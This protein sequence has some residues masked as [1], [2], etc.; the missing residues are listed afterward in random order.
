MISTARCP[1]SWNARSRWSGIP[2]PTWMSGDVTSMPSFTRNGRPSLS[3]ASSPP[4][5]R[6]STALRVRSASM[7]AAT[8]AGA[9]T[10]LRRKSRAPKRRRI[11]KLRL[12]ALLFVLGLLGLSSF[13]FGLLTSVSA[14]VSG[15]DPQHQ[16]FQQ[17]NTYVYANN[18]TSI[19][20]VLH[21]SEARVIVPSKDISPWVKHAI[22]AIE[23][24]RFYEH[25]GVD[26]HGISRALWTDITHG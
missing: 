13:T 9:L 6:T 14:Q 18:G 12:L 21:G 24:K 3:F 23:D 26:V 17:A 7:A 4:S 25:R 1:A 22:V 10:L 15:L 20:E 19:L 11:R 8:L 16:K 2:R 5:G